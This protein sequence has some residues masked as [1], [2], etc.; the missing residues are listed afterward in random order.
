[1]QEQHRRSVL[2]PF[3]L[4]VE[5]DAVALD[6]PGV[7]HVPD[8]TADAVATFRASACVLPWDAGADRGAGSWQ[9]PPCLVRPLL[10]RSCNGIITS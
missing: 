9:L 1:M 6:P 5:I 2:W 7:G 3:E 10:V 4:D 8:R